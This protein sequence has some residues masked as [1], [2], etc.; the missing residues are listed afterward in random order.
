MRELIGGNNIYFGL[1][2]IKGVRSEDIDKL[3]K[4]PTCNLETPW[5]IF[6]LT[7]LADLNYCSSKAL[8]RSGGLDHYKMDRQAMLTDLANWRELN[9]SEQAYAKDNCTNMNSMA[10]IFEFVVENRKFRGDKRKSKL[11]EILKGMENPASPIVDTVD[12]II[13]AEEDL[14]GL[15]ITNHVTD[16]VVNVLQ[17]HTCEDILKRYNKYAVLKVRID[18]SREYEARNGMMLFMKVSDN[19]GSLESCVAFGDVYESNKH[20]L[21]EDSLVFISGKL[22]LDRNSF[23]IQRVYSV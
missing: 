4:M 13:Y 2:N 11:I 22:N 17:T 12:S 19:S 15:A 7:I 8:I 16:N 23:Q 3:I 6:L 18:Q 5:I 21:T 20:L 10:S 14:L 1:A 9:E